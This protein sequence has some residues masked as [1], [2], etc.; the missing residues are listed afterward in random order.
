MGPKH[1]RLTPTCA[2]FARAQDGKPQE[3][4]PVETLPML[5]LPVQTT[6][7]L[8]AATAGYEHVG[9]PCWPRP[10]FR[11]VTSTANSRTMTPTSPALIRHCKRHTSSRPASRGNAILEA[12]KAF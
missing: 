5:S 7:G 3:A 10:A 9:K 4:V 1:S 8:H 12:T 6:A 2:L 11:A